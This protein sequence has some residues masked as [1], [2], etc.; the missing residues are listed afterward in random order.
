MLECDLIGFHLFEYAKN[1]MTSCKK[2]L[3]LQ[4]EFRRGGFLGVTYNGR[5]VMLRIGHVGI[6]K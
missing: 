4:Y 5:H 1:F 3:D 2:L 6:E